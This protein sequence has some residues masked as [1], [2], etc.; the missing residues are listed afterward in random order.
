MSAIGSGVKEIRI[1]E[2]N[3][4]RV[5]YSISPNLQK[6]SM[7]CTLSPRKPNRLERKIWNWRRIATSSWQTKET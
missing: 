6:P 5:L 2:E 3:E 7:C 4:Y 1:H